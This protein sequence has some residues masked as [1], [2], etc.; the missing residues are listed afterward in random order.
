MSIDQ[1]EW[2]GATE[3]QINL[4]HEL[5]L[6]KEVNSNLTIDYASTLIDEAIA[7]QKRERQRQIED[8]TYIPQWHSDPASA[9]QLSYLKSLDSSVDTEGMTKK[10]ASD[11]IGKLKS[12][13]KRKK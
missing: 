10:E 7:K 3:K 8:G 9:K 6:G 12:K 2:N 13:K 5:G 11:A 1:A 4:M